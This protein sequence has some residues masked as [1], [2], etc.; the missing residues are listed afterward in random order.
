M[1]AVVRRGY[2][3]ECGGLYLLRKDGTLRVHGRPCSGAGREPL[4]T[5]G[6]AR[7]GTFGQAK[8]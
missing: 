5:I 6:T 1:G 4:P 7:L 2:C 8:R 3:S